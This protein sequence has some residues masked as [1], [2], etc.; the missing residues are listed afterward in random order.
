MSRELCGA[1]EARPLFK[2]EPL[3]AARNETRGGNLPNTSMILTLF[4]F[5]VLV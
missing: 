2:T 1:A 5:S 3:A 4:S